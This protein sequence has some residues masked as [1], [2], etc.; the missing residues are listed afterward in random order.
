ME[1]P[2]STEQTQRLNEE[3]TLAME[4]T[5][6]GINQQGETMQADNST[7]TLEGAEPN[8]VDLVGSSSLFTSED[9]LLNENPETNKEV[10]TKQESSS[11]PTWGQS[12]GATK[13]QL[14]EDWQV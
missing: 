3:A 5:E 12:K 8:H 2:S 10:V 14:E 7:K 9:R 11:N 1:S 6:G 4:K 13:E